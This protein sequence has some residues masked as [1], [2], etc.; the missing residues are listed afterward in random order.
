MRQK[1]NYDLQAHG[2][3]FAV[4]EIMWGYSPKKKKRRCPKSDSHWEGPCWGTTL[5]K[6]Y[7]R[8][9]Q[10]H[11][12]QAWVGRLMDHWQPL[13][14]LIPLPMFPL[15]PS[16]CRLLPSLEVPHPSVPPKGG[17]LPAQFK[18][19]VIPQG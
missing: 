19:F 14:N 5:G 17:K 4:G 11:W 6:S 12:S 8:S 15:N 1:R 13:L 3:H 9:L 10:Q 2:Q 7:L 16:Q 18:D